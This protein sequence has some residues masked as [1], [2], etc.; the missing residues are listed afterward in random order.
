MST[1][2][3]EIV[4]ARD[5]DVDAMERLERA[6]F[7]PSLAFSRRQLRSL[8]RAP[9]VRAWVLRHEGRVAGDVISLCRQGGK[10]ARVYSLAVLPRH[11]GKGFG[12][13][14]LG[15]CLEKLRAAGARK[16]VLEVEVENDSAAGLYE[17]FGFRK[18]GRLHDYYAPGLDAW[19][20]RLV[21]D[22]H[23]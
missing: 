2:P 8:L 19:K 22:A 16:I 17:A 23:E 6:C 9:T 12:K 14:L 20:M 5:D 18:I 10:A 3:F 13:A 11:R 21:I 1:Q 15:A 7:A 4:P